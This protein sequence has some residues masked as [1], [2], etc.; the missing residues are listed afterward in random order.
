LFSAA[1]RS[2]VADR[3]DLQREE[4]WRQNDKRFGGQAKRNL[5]TVGKDSSRRKAVGHFRQRLS[6]Q[7]CVRQSY[8]PVG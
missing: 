8:N 4:N 3:G 2:D 6:S 1:A 7:V 5:Q